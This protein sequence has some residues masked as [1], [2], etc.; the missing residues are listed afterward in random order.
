VGAEVE[1]AH[2]PFAGVAYSDGVGVLH[3]AEAPTTSP[4]SS[5]AAGHGRTIVTDEWGNPAGPW[6]IKRAVRASRQVAGL[7]KDLR[8]RDL[9]HY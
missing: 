5:V 1:E 4:T 8:L 2:D 3:L 7:P 6:T 9:R